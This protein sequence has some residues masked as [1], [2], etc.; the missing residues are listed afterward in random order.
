MEPLDATLADQQKLTGGIDLEALLLLQIL[1]FSNA[2]MD[3]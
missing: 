3:I 1:E 2:E